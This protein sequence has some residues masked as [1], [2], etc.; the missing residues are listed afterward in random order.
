MKIC[1][2]STAAIPAFP[3]PNLYS[4]AEVVV[5]NLAIELAKSPKKHQVYVITAKGSTMAGLWEYEDENTHEKLGTLEVRE[6]VMPNMKDGLAEL[7]H[8]LAYKEWLEHNFGDGQGVVLDSTWQ[9][10][11]YLTVSGY[12]GN[13][14]GIGQ[15]QVLP[16]PK[17][18]LIHVHHGAPNASSP[19]PNVP[20]PRIL[21]LSRVHAGLLSQVMRTPARYMW[22]GIPLP[23][24]TPEQC[25]RD[26]GNK[27]INDGKPYLLSLNRMT[28]EKGI[29]DSIDIAVRNG[30]NII[31]AGDDI[32]VRDPEYVSHIVEMCRRSNQR[33][34]YYG[35][36]DNHTKEELLK[37]CMGV[38]SCPIA[39]GPKAWVE[40]FGLNVVEGL[41]H[42]KPFI[43]T[44]NGGHMDIIEHGKHGFLGFNAGE[45]SQYVHRLGEIDGN[46]CRQRVEEEFTLDKMTQRY[47]LLFE[48]VDKGNPQ[49]N[50]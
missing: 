3:D 1:I 6:T 29:H 49:F 42:Y 2:I 28:E 27:W 15:L 48:E 30:V 35:S 26:N 9:M 8:Y 41:A 25:P 7:N 50:W 18:K 5:S 33:A 4:G 31:V 14:M 34:I 32:L 37:H 46:V 23:N 11:S 12:D 16:H 43:G 10:F 39:Q 21:G 22:N 13:I 36:I 17:M 44:S 45:I 38:I 24:V 20:H 47:E 40:A 19:P